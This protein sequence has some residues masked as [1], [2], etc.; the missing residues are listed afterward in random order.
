MKTTI[1]LI[2]LL[3]MSLFFQQAQAQISIISKGDE[4]SALNDKKELVVQDEK[5]KLAEDVKAINQ[6]LDAGK[7]DSEEAEK[8]KKE[9]AKRRALNIED[10]L[11]IIDSQIAL[12]QREEGKETNIR[13]FIGSNLFNKKENEVITDSIPKS[14]FSGPYIAFGLNNAIPESGSLNDS[15]YKIGGSRFFEV[16]YEFTTFLTDFMRVKYG[17]SFQFNGLKPEGNLYFEQDDDETYLAEYP[18]NLKKSKFRNDNLVIPIHFEF[19][20]STIEQGRKNSYH[21]TENLFKVG[22]GGYAGLNMNTV[23]KLKYKDNGH[24]EKSKLKKGYNTTNFIYGLSAY[25]GYDWYALY[26]KYDLNPIF[27]NNAIAE[28]NVSLGV[29]LAF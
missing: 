22:V 27:T 19:G 15:P 3:L 13:V 9:A 5:A 7:I 29:R 10:R 20:G 4:I 6:R 12:L 11:N 21:S 16:G 23:Q 26:I 25:V 14:T 1:I 28:H 17:V 2:S 8:L 18:I 24:H